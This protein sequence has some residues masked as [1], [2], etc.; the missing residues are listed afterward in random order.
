MAHAEL[1]NIADGPG[2]FNATL[3]ASHAPR[4]G[5][6]SAVSIA[7][8]YATFSTAFAII[9]AVVYLITLMAACL[10]FVALFTL[11]TT[12]ISERVRELATLKVLGFRR[13]EV[14][15]YVNREGA[16]LTAVGIA[17]G[18]PLGKWLGNP[19][20]GALQTSSVY[21]AV[22]VEPASYAL[23]IV[24]VLIFAALVSAITNRSL[25]RIDMVEA[26]KNVE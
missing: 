8:L 26:L 1:E 10:A 16:I 13:G 14:R 2:G 22:H 12:N 5:V 6:A 23:T 24:L 19:L 21:F 17:L 25:D 11:S 18:L 9:N 20:T 3:R 15:R 7:R 4:D